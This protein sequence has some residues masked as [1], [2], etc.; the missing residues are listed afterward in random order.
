VERDDI[1]AFD[2]ALTHPYVRAWA[3]RCVGAVALGTAPLPKEAAHLAAIAASAAIRA[4]LPAEIDVPVVDGY[5]CLPTLGRLRAD[6]AAVTVAVTE[7]GFDA[8]TTDHKWRVRLADPEPDA[9]WQP[10]RELRSGT[11]TVALEDTDPY[12]DTH[13]WPAANRLPAGDVDR[14]QR[15]FAV[16]WRLIERAFPRYLPGLTGGLST[17]MPLAGVDQDREISA[18]SRHAFGAVAAALPADGDVLALLILHEV[19]H[20]KL[21]AVLDL[22]DLC[23]PADRQL[24]NAPWRDD[25]RP[26]EPLLQGAYAH[27]AV[28]DYWRVRRHD[29]A[30]AR[31]LAAEERFARWRMHTAQAIET[32]IGSGAL[33]PLGIRFVEGMQ[34]TVLD[35]L[36]EPV[37]PSALA[38]AHARA[39]ERQASRRRQQE[40]GEP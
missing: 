15:Q 22:F 28:T 14:W 35:W 9:D 30:D 27:L 21:G 39:D 7:G 2:L 19:Q 5:A 32:L 24:F 11:F 29:L 34:A 1:A 33:T 26:A 20:V 12:R 40:P 8:R 13:Q 17:L 36:D 38:A 25:P 3:D 23:D 31:A 37:P 4:C 18:A 10:V 16:A 6:A